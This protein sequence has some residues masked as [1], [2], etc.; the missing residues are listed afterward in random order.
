MPEKTTE[1]EVLAVLAAQLPQTARVMNAAAITEEIHN[2]PDVGPLQDEDL[3]PEEVYDEHE[4]A[5]RLL[6]EQGLV[7]GVEVFGMVAYH[8][9][10]KGVEHVR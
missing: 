10:E 8:L 9:T 1:T 3:A 7:A 4:A 5:L 6:A 2:G